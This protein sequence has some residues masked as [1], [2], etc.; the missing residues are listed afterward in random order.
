MD[1]KMPFPISIIILYHRGEIYLKAC[2][3]SI[4]NTVRDTDEIIVFINNSDRNV[5]N[6]DFYKEKVKFI[7]IYED[8]G[9]SKAANKAIDYALNDYVIFCDQDIVFQN[10]WLPNL[11][12]SYSSKQNVGI[13]GVKLINHL[14]NTIL[15]FGVASSEYNF[16][17]PNLGLDIEHPLVKADREVQMVCSA[18]LLISKTDFNKIGGFYE[19]FGTLYSD[20]DFCLRAKDIGLKVIVSSNAVAYHFSGE[21][22]QGDRSYKNNKGDIKGVFM[23]KNASR[24]RNDADFFLEKSFRYLQTTCSCILPAYM[25]CN[26]MSITNYYYYEDLILS[27]GIHK[28]GS[29]RK[30][31][32][33]RDAVHI[34]IFNILGSNIM[35]IGVDIIYLVDRFSSL[36]NNKFWWEHRKSS[37]DLIVDRH[38]NICTVKEIFQSRDT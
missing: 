6:I 20:L 34:D 2:L 14:D 4:I 26:L 12:K 25:F 27:Y 32:E 8:L 23:K 16:I 37:N 17:H 35:D 29:Y 9:Y 18:V 15:D 10:N 22:F 36:R 31:I 7:H 38:A 13:A 19:P 30:Q 33:S 1:G 5:H 24:I 3:N 28:Y 21:Y 11:W